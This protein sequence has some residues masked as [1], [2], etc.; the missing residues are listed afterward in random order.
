MAKVVG[1]LGWYSSLPLCACVC[2]ILHTDESCL[3]I[4]MYVLNSLLE[5]AHN[6]V[7]IACKLPLQV[8]NNSETFRGW[9]SLV[10][11]SEEIASSLVCTFQ[12]Q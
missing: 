7:K 2:F 4:Y 11:G 1:M 10:G 6:F 3:P 8:H 5:S 12:I 9:F